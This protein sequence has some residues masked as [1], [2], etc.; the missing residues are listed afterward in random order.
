MSYSIGLHFRIV[1]STEDF[2]KLIENLQKEF[3]S[4]T[5]VEEIVKSDSF[6]RY[7]NRVNFSVQMDY[8]LQESLLKNFLSFKLYYWK[9]LNLVGYCYN[10][11]ELPKYLEKYF[12]GFICFQNSCDQN[13][14]YETWEVL[15]DWVKPIIQKFSNLPKK[16][17]DMI[18]DEY[19]MDEDYRKQTLV[20]ET[21][22]KQMDID[23]TL[24]SSSSDIVKC[25]EIVPPT[26]SVW[27]Y[28]LLH[29]QK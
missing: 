19:D 14:P 5:T 11:T 7:L 22:F 2:L 3:T 28:L 9:D 18:D 26:S 21:I 8:N 13:Y 1:K 16:G 12:N 10:S 29:S 6:I 17:L 23:S 20:Y 24:N 4:K 25:I 27:D 15:G